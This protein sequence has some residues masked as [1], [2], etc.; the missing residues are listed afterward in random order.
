M[1]DK[2]K[3]I[4]IP[5]LIQEAERTGL[6]SDEVEQAVEHEK[7]KAEEKIEQLRKLYR[8]KIISHEQLE[9]GI[10]SIRKELQFRILEL[11]I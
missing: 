2:I 11:N 5:V 10:R 9:M 7:L 4:S 3:T 1:T 6:I 8:E